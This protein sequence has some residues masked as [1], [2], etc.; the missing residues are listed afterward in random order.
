[1]NTE[2]VLRRKH[3]RDAL[4]R[5]VELSYNAEWD[6]AIAKAEEAVVVMKAIRTQIEAESYTPVD[7]KDIDV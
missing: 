2:F 4:V 1:M 3:S 6:R 5:A 7:H